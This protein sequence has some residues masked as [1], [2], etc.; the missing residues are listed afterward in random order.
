VCVSVCVNVCVL[1]FIYV[2]VC[3]RV[4]EI[5]IMRVHLRINTHGCVRLCVCVSVCV[6]AKSYQISAQAS[7]CI[8]RF[9]VGA[10]VISDDEDFAE[11]N[12]L[13]HCDRIII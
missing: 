13:I 5:E 4:C 7:Y 3:V 10:V 2:C 1:I 11:V 6:C 8:C 12:R 9:L